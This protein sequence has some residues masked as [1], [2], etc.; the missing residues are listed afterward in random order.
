VSAVLVI[1]EVALCVVLM[2]GAGLLVRSFWKLIHVDPGF[3][4][5]NVLVARIWLP[6]PNDPK[7]DPYASGEARVA[8]MR[9]V[10]R[11][12]S[13]LPGTMFA[14]ITNNLP[15]SGDANR[16]PIAVETQTAPA[17]ESNSAEILTISPEYFAALRTPILEGRHFKESDQ[18]GAEPVLIVDHATAQRFWPGQTAIGKRVKMGP[19]L[20]RAPFATVVG[21]VADVR[22]DGIAVDGVP[23]IYV[24]V[25]QR[26]PKAMGIVLR[27][28]SDPARLMNEVTR[29]IQ[30]VDPNLPVFGVRT[31]DEMAA[32]SVSQQHISA[33][34]VGAFAICALLLAAIGVYGVLAYSVGQR[35]REIGI[36][37][38]LGA[39]RA[40]V[41]KL[42]LWQNALVILGGVAAGVATALAVSQA[43]S[44]LLFGVSPRD[45]LV[46]I[47]VPAILVAVALAASYL[48]AVRASRIDPVTALRCE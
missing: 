45:P 23:H 26:S 31:L 40:E 39:R 16:Q 42:V 46:M 48:P 24:S 14:A 21:V 20:S 38:A 30:A 33:Q 15:T 25:Y 41:V 12:V 8:F 22:H 3:D 28:R 47:A 2:T 5:H 9:E 36:R 32:A 27:A 1:S 13:A 29:Q 4:P 6:Q 18:R 34:V 35:T 44:R 7:A 11:R 17:A 43:L 19:A 37:M 10:L